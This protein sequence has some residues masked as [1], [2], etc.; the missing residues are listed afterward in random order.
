MVEDVKVKIAA[1]IG[2]IDVTSVM[3]LPAKYPKAVA[4]ATLV[5]FS[6][7]FDLEFFGG[8][9]TVDI[10]AILKTLEI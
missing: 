3:I 4:I 7:N 6:L 5:T 8:F 10:L 9:K 2:S 1:H